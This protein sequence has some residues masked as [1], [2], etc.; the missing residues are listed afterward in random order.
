MQAIEGG[1]RPGAGAPLAAPC[2]VVPRPG[3]GAL[4]AAPCLRASRPFAVLTLL[5]SLALAACGGGAGQPSGAPPPAK[6]APAGQAP[7]ASAPSAEWDALVAAARQEGRLAVSIPPGQLWRQ[8]IGSFEQDFPGIQIELSGANSRDFWPRV[9]QERQ[10]DVYNW[11]LRVGGPDPD[12]YQG[13]R[14]GVFDP[15][16][17]LLVLPE[18]TDDGK[19]L[20]GLDGLFVDAE[21]RWFP[22]FI[23]NTSA[24]FYVNRDIIPESDLRT[25]TDILDPRWKGKIAIQDPRGGAGLGRL[26]AMLIAHGEGSVR[27]LLTKQDVVATGDNRQIAEWVVRG[28]YPIGIGISDST[29]TE[30]QKEGLGRN[31]KPLSEG[32]VTLSPGFGGLQLLNRAPHPKAVQVFINWILTREVQTRIAQTVQLN[33][34]RLDV[35]PGDPATAPDPAKLN[36]YILNQDEVA[37]VPRERA[38]A[39]AMELLK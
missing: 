25:D 30:L 26:T 28:R 15:I 20:G 21:D 27:D 19:W 33:S 12:S 7:A 18:V 34:R 6:P 4:L 5:L 24:A 22:G 3:V 16:R 23:A 14:Q 35:P 13:Y 1:T 11:D 31:V 17:P 8:A 38:Q 37:L 39:L 36:D 2:P 32:I 29:L 10:G 9:L